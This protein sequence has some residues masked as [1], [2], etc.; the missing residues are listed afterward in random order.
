MNDYE[1]L[2]ISALCNAGMDALGGEEATP[3]GSIT[4]N[5]LPFQIGPKDGGDRCF[6]VLDGSS[7]TLKLDVEGSAHSVIVAHRLLESDLQEGGVVGKTVAEYVFRLAGGH[8]DRVAIRERFDISGPSERLGQPPAYRAV[9]RYLDKLPPRHEGPWGETGRRQ[10]EVVRGDALSYSLWVWRNPHPDLEVEAIEIVPS[11]P[12]FIV[13]AVTLGHVDEYPFVRQ[14]RREAR[15]TLTDRAEAEREFDLEV[16]VD[17]GMAT[18]AHP[19]PTAPSEEFLA[20][21]MGGWGEAQSSA[22]G[23]AVVEIAATPS[24]TVTIKQGGERLGSV[25]WGDVEDKGVA[26][27]AKARVE[28]LD[29]G[30][31]WVHVT[32]LDD[33]TGKPVPCRVHFRSPEG[34]PYQPHGHHNRVNS[35]LDTWH[36]DVGGD[37]RLG[38]TTYA[39]IDGTCQGWLPRGE[40]LV[41]AARGFEYEPL[42]TRVHIE[43]G[44]RELT[45]R[46]KRWTNMNA[47]GWYS[48][49]SHVHFLSTQGSHLESQGE[50]LNVVNLLQSQWGDL[51]TNTEEFTGRPS[52]SQDGN[53]IVY[54]LQENRQHFL[55]HMILWGLK[56]PVMPWC[57]DGSTRGRAR[58]AHGDDHE[59]LGRP[60]P[61]AGGPRDHPAL[62]QSQRGAAGADRD[63]TRRRGRDDSVR[64]IQPRGVLP[65][66]ELRLP[67]A[68]S[69]R[70]RQ[71]ELRRAGRPVP[72]VHEAPRGRG[73]QLRDMVRQRGQG[74][75]VPVRRAHHAL[76]GRRSRGR[77]HGPAYGR[78]DG[79][80]R[81][82]GGERAADAPA[83]DREERA[84]RCRDRL[85]QRLQT[86]GAA[87]EDRRR[88][89]LV[90]GGPVRRSVLL[91]Q[92][93]APRRLVAGDLRTHLACVRRLRRR[94]ADVRPPG[95]PVHADDDRGRAGLHRRNVS[96]ARAG[97]GD[98]PPRRGRPHGVPA[99][100]VPRGPGRRAEKARRTRP[101]VTAGPAAPWWVLR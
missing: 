76:R 71:D 47:Q 82:L 8:E 96:Q 90:A 21:A 65:V 18:Y 52:V 67:P 6:V 95:R 30:R 42:R 56:E 44:Q 39:Y 3:T 75:N 34:V 62:S 11:G 41:D 60:L 2:D 14:G 38:Q 46:L 94:L 88:R 48:G 40:V 59:P 74:P 99:T 33:E 9:T 101:L 17:R 58:R 93:P 77:R 13:S 28:L 24:A 54:A 91:R 78:G 68:P 1:P 70:H 92:R 57:S 55:G 20:D 35:N 43:R 45:L 100:P 32:V 73:V 31:N 37:L 12:R 23:P 51:F 26:E 36:I 86:V 25:R 81:G 66:P 64:A 87:R 16:E 89:R 85:R 50:D 80:G 27:T 61:R 69:G 84:G 72:D 7:G 97:V 5:G 4:I 83:G 98:A 22:S 49:D 79:G 29:R 19:L 10:M 63:R 15:I 53:N